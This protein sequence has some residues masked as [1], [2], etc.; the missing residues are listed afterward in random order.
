MAKK[1]A[2]SPTR[3]CEKC[4]AKYHPRTAK[5]PKCGKPNPTA[6]RKAERKKAG[7]KTRKPAPANA[8]ETLDAAITFVEQA[9]SLNAAK[10]AIEKIEKIRGL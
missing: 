8:G 3:T 6:G 10:A 9:G 4:G 5:C 7:R 2:K 1:K